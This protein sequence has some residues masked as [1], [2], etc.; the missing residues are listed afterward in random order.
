MLY[1][2]KQ[3]LD[4][5]PCFVEGLVIVARAFALWSRWYHDGLSR[6]LKR[7][8]HPRVSVIALV[9]Q[10]GIG[11]QAGQQHVRS[12]EITG[13]PWR[14]M[15]AQRVSQ[16]ITCGM[17]FRAQSAFGPPDALGFFD[18]PLAPAAC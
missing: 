1:F 18:R 6:R 9:C 15:K 2:F 16:S 10:H 3:V 7:V 12:I 11:L 14:E 4:Q 17:N 8:N 13:L 5:M